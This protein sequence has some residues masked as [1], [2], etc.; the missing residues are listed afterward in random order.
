MKA[1][2]D[3][4]HLL[5]SFYNMIYTQFDTSIKVI[6]SDNAF[7]FSLPDFYNAHGIVHQKTCAYTPQQNFVVER[8]HQHLLN[9]ARS[10]KLQSN[11]PS[12][13]W[14]DCIL[15]ATY[16]INRCL[17]L[18]Y[19]ISPFLNFFSINHLHLITL[20]SLDVCV[21]SLLLLFIG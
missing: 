10:L 6:R 21:L 18:C 16:L 4:K 20:E 3:V 13:Y 2:L 5:I 1:K 11:L 8:K 15:I 12:A 7:E 17:F 9:V 19:K 14:G